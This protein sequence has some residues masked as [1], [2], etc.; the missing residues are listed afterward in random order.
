MKMKMKMKMNGK[1]KRPSNRSFFLIYRQG[2]R[3]KKPNK[4]VYNRD[5]G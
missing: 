5:R 4:I 1:M 3:N 2:S